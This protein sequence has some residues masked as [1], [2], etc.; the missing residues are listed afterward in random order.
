MKKMNKTWIFLGIA[1]L[2]ASACAQND[3]ATSTETDNETI[4]VPTTTTLEN[5]TPILIMERVNETNSSLENPAEPSNVTENTTLETNQTIESTTTT[6]E[7]TT[8]T[9]EETTT[10]EAPTTTIKSECGNLYQEVGEECDT[11]ASA[12]GDGRWQCVDCKCVP[13]PDETTTTLA[14]INKIA[15]IANV[16]KTMN[17]N[18]I[19]VWHVI[20]VVAVVIALILG[21]IYKLGGKDGNGKD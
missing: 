8:T 16:Q 9:I 21:A 11:T 18:N 6:I 13:L 15:T 3:P 10:T 17:D 1:L 5:V 12:C 19:T 14:S 20:G 4:I 2:I 7:P